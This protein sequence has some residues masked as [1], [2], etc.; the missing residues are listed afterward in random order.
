MP[1]TSKVASLNYTK[2]TLSSMKKQKKKLTAKTKEIL[3]YIIEKRDELAKNVFKFQDNTIVH[4]PVHF[5]RNILNI[6]NNLRI[7]GNFFVDITPLDLYEYVE[8][9]FKSLEHYPL[10]KPTE[11]FKIL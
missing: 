8:D 3:N 2:K 9:A 1:D 7:K 5:E 4:I 11:L 10:T 6:K